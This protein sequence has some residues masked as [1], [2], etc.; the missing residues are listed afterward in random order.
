MV[1]ALSRCGRGSQLATG[2]P[3]PHPGEF[4]GNTIQGRD[5]RPHCHPS[6]PA[7]W[8]PRHTAGRQRNS[9]SRPARGTLPAATGGP[10][11]GLAGL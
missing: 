10:S 5:L 11:D 9:P 4:D 6:P 2:P 1:E 7:D 3:V 8:A